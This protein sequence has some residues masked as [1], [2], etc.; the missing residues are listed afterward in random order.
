MQQADAL[1]YY[2]RPNGC[3]IYEAHMYAAGNYGS[4]MDEQDWPAY[5]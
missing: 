4:L 1:D 2:E 5:A 3:Y